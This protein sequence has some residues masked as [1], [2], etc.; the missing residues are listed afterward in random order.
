MAKITFS[1]FNGGL[2]DNWWYGQAVGTFLGRDDIFQ[3]T[4]NQIA[5]GRMNP[6]IKEG[7]LYPNA[8]TVS[9]VN[10]TNQLTDG[11]RVVGFVTATD[12]YVDSS[13]KRSIFFAQGDKFHAYHITSN[14]IMA[15]TDTPN[16]FPITL[17][18]G[19]LAAPHTSH[20]DFEID[21]IALYQINGK[22]TVFMSFRD[23][24]DADLWA[25]YITDHQALSNNLLYN[26]T[27]PDGTGITGTANSIALDKTYKTFLVPADNTFMYVFNGKWCHK[28][29]GNAERGTRGQVTMNVL[30]V[31]SSRMFA[32]AC[33][34]DGKMYIAV[35]NAV[36]ASQAFDNDN[37]PTQNITIL[38]WDRVA[39]RVGVS[40][41]ISFQA[42]D[43][44]NIFS[45]GRN[46]YTW[47]KEDDLNTVL[48]IVTE[49]NKLEKLKVVGH[50]GFG[51]P[52]NRHA[53][54]AFKNGII[55][56]ESQGAILYWDMKNKGLHIIYAPTSLTFGYAGALTLRNGY[57]FL[58]NRYAGTD[59]F[60]STLNANSFGADA[61]NVGNG[62][63]EFGWIDIPKYSTID[64][65][66]VYYKPKN[67]SGKTAN[68]TELDLWFTDTNTT[69]VQKYIY[70]ADWNTGMKYFPIGKK[71]VNK[72]KFKIWFDQAVT[73]QDLIEIYKIEVDYTPSQ[74][75]K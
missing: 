12:S 44:Y 69:P 17:G 7:I 18:G 61:S 5:F 56:Q 16:T 55:W 1:G 75:L 23:N 15:G 32:D 30:T 54:I 47:T 72:F 49:D 53:I 10:Q 68:T 71:Y 8:D 34:H 41:A 42:E 60:V 33:D 65:I 25:Y 21:D 4:G 46:V 9:D 20:T 37:R 58:L 39:A 14:K 3:T 36:P 35:K 50:Q 19:Y 24:T 22:D 40:D 52:A 11:K 43:I 13:K 6:L 26:A 2:V 70:T 64:G 66:T 73:Y 28:F 38:I 67:T 63:L 48:S 45:D 51:I 29:D 31:E 74:R 62:N 59:E 57:T 27:I